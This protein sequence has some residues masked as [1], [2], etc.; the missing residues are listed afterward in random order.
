M[1]GMRK[2]A[3][4]LGASLAAL[5][6]PAAAQSDGTKRP[7]AFDYRPVDEDERS[8]WLEMDEQERD[9]RNSPFLMTD[10]ALNAYVR[11]VLCRT[12][13]EERCGAT[14]IYIL[15][16]PHFNAAMA[17]NGM[18]VVW[19]GLL[20]RA[21]NE[22]ELATVL[23]HEF[24]HFDQLHSLQSARDIRAKTDAMTW[25]S[26][27]PGGGLAQIGLFGSVFQFNRDMERQADMQALRYL[28][29]SG[30]APEAAAQIWEQLR[31]EMDS[32][33]Q[34]KAMRRITD[35]EG[36]NFFSSHP[37][38]KQRMDYLRD[39]AG[40][41]G[42]TGKYLGED[43]HRAALAAWWPQLIDDQIKLDDFSVTEFLLQSVA[44][45][46]WTAG[47]YYAHGELYRARAEKSDFAKAAGLYRSAIA[48]DKTLAE[49]WRGLG[50]ALLRSGDK[51]GGKA[52]LREYLARRLDAPDKAIIAAM[53]DAI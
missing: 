42:N 44:R 16:T 25:L 52:A 36:S 3:V 14:R 51:M 28:A 40:R 19:S 30:Y 43:R 49:S 45:D 27:L 32:S 26:F 29:A 2:W 38:S 34:G 10:P 35:G 5:A 48:K 8:L 37:S 12:V 20:L 17:P 9:V 1:K 13:G 15:R 22:A 47:L 24:A 7:S 6:L 41:L 11:S 18:M 31:A 4:F 33:K 46:D 21:R 39:A 50:L 23:G 53:A